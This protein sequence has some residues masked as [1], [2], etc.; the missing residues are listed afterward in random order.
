M[1]LRKTIFLKFSA[2]I[3]L[4]TIVIAGFFTYYS[5]RSHIK[6]S[7]RTLI[8]RLKI[9]SSEFNRMILWDDR[10]AVKRVLNN[11]VNTNKLLGYAFISKSGNS[12]ESSFKNGIPVDLLKINFLFSKSSHILEFENIKG[13]IYYD[14]SVRIGES[15]S[16]LH[17]G[18]IKSQILKE[19]RL[20]FIT[21]YSTCLILIIVGI[22]ISYYLSFKM[23]SEITI[24]SNAIRKYN[25]ESG[26]EISIDEKK[27]EIE[28]IVQSFNELI[29]IQKLAASALKESEIN[30]TKIAREWEATFD[31]IDDPVAL[32]DNKG[33]ILRCNSSQ[34]KM[35]KQDFSKIIG[36]NAINLLHNGKQPEECLIKKVKITK[37]REERVFRKDNLWFKCF[38][39]PVFNNSGI[40]VGGV[41]VLTNITKQKE[42]D[43]ALKK[44]ENRLI[45]AQKVA[46]IGHYVY[47]FNSDSWESSNGL[48]DI[49]GIDNKYI[50]N[51]DGWIKIVHPDQREMMVKYFQKDILLEHRKFDKE[52]KIV[53]HKSGTVRWVHGLGNLEFDKKGNHVEMFGTI[54]DITDRK[55]AEDRYKDLVEKA[56]IAILIDDLEGNFIYFNNRFNEIFGYTPEEL[57]KKSKFSLVHPHHLN[58]VMKLHKSRQKGEKVPTRYEFDGVKKDGTVINLET[59]VVLLKEGDK[60]IGTRSYSWDI[61]ERKNSEEQFRLIAENTGDNITIITFDDKAE[62]RYV[63]PSS[64]IH[65]GYDPLE[66][67]GK[68]FFNFVHNDD[69]KIL[70][71]ML[72]K[73]II[74]KNKKFLIGKE[75]D[76]NETLEF[77]FK[78]KEGN[79]IDLQSTVNIMGDN[80]IAV[81]R[82][83]TERK[84][85]QQALK[86]SEEKYRSLSSN[87][88]GIVYRYHLQG[89]KK[90]EIVNNYLEVITGYSKLELFIDG[91]FSLDQI[92]IPEDRKF[93]TNKLRSS[94]KSGKSFEIEYRLIHKDGSLK[95]VL[96]IGSPVFDS[97]KKPLYIDGIILDNT[98][99][100]A[101]LEEI[102]KQKAFSQTSIDALTHPFYIIDVD[103]HEIVMKNIESIKFS[104]EFDSKC[105]EIT[106]GRSSP[107]SGKD[108]PCPIIEIKKNKKPIVVEHEHSDDKGNKLIHEVHGFPIFNEEGEVIQIIEYCLD[109]S[110][111]KSAQEESMKQQSELMRADKLISLGILVSGV[112]HEIN[113][114]NNAILL[115]SELLSKV[116]R[117]L[118]PIINEMV[119]N[120]SS[121][122]IGGLGFETV[123][124]KAPELFA[125]ITKSSNRIKSIVED[126]KKYSR[127]DK[128]DDYTYININSVIKS[129]VNLMSSFISKYTTNFELKLSEDTPQ[130]YANFQKIEQVIIN[131]IQNSCQSLRSVSDSL[132]ISTETDTK[133]DYLI[134][135]VQDKGRGIKKKDLK[136]ITEPFFTTKRETGGTGLGLSVSEKI[137]DEHNGNMK[138]SSAP[139]KGT[140]VKIFLPISDNSKLKREAK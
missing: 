69:K 139:G 82:D 1:S 112:A 101:A 70:R 23:T 44:S 56:G 43:E 4:L 47:Y 116:W 88:P 129:A 52:Y 21:F 75:M 45:E 123:K 97:A 126:L 110:E 32:I 78:G 46:K 36:C 17:M 125:G 109:I 2:L 92:I 114:P 34:R 37:R 76:I 134:T 31:A 53:N 24:L 119:R 51:M 83:I 108:H 18:L 90:F 50:M 49:F 10:I 54:Q 77:K 15:D 27:G 48:N 138:F 104:S 98:I 103:T 128:H 79:W 84:K 117:D 30:L 135:T 60:P 96:E 73:Y 12:Y 87:L 93:V 130:I 136:F 133:N 57:K 91:R 105:F 61:T 80:L 72:K 122:R 58:E 59:E 28:K 68:S 35:L 81:S 71:H 66:M 29:E 25:E 115:N 41:H 132:S 8:L 120:D 131:L 102:K 38:I 9:I 137:I 99:Q 16:I 95:N 6:D 85:T 127:K 121:I 19:Q 94:M 67:I 62:F 5:I 3:I 42:L 26:A 14:I 63:S 55:I 113:N 13:E 107:C 20:F 40:V 74:E 39:D 7:Q 106:H 100:R 118:S 89:E 33:V 86:E 22:I 11:E 140:V 64:K 111:K 124:H 65:F